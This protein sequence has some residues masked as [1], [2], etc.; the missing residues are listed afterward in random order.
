M[1]VAA[2]HPMLWFYF[3][4]HGCINMAT[5]VSAADD[6]TDALLPTARQED[7]TV[8]TGDALLLAY[9]RSH[10]LRVFSACR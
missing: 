7:M 1:T 5:H 6:V 9:A 4:D 8:M 3:N 2:V 10:H